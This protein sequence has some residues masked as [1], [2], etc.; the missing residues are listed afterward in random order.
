MD[1]RLISNPE[2]LTDDYL[3]PIHI[4][5]QHKGDEDMTKRIV[6]ITECPYCDAGVYLKTQA[7]LDAEGR[8]DLDFAQLD[9]QPNQ[10]I[11]F[12]DRCE[13]DS[14]PCPHLYLLD[15]ESQRVH[16][17]PTMAGCLEFAFQHPDVPKFKEE[18]GIHF[19]LDPDSHPRNDDT[20]N[21]ESRFLHR[22]FRDFWFD[23]TDPKEPREFSVWGEVVFVEDVAAF[24]AELPDYHTKLDAWIAAGRPQPRHIHHDDDGEYEYEEEIPV[25]EAEG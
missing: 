2:I 8:Y 4:S 1:M 21:F 15:G 24:H 5:L 17:Y 11:V 22:E 10:Q 20:A 16:E 25:G 18:T 9:K 7:V 6:T 13:P 19:G 14:P 23:R 12:Y 3:P